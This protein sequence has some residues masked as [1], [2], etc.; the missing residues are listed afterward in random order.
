M[1]RR[2]DAKH[3]VAEAGRETTTQVDCSAR[4]AS[5]APRNRSGDNSPAAER[6]K[7]GS[8]SSGKRAEAAKPE[9]RDAAASRLAEE[10]AAAARAVDRVIRPDAAEGPGE[11]ETAAR[12]RRSSRAAR[13][14]VLAQPPER[15]RSPREPIPSDRP[16]RRGATRLSTNVAL[17]RSS[18]DPST[19]SASHSPDRSAIAAASIGAGV[20][21]ASSQSHRILSGGCQSAMTKPGRSARPSRS[22]IRV[23]RPRKA[24][25]DSSSPDALDAARAHGDAGATSAPPRSVKIG[26]PRKITSAG[27]FRSFEISGIEGRRDRRRNL[28]GDEARAAARRRDTVPAGDRLR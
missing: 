7:S 17:D 20:S 18:A 16:L 28:L 23:R 24:N 2:V 9:R 6:T 27:P 10:S 13:G 26:P 21:R 4:S 14:R 12:L 5:T 8:S 25:T 3:V 22:I 11:A 19:I 1:R 15:R